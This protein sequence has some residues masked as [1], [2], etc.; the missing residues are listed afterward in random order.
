MDLARLV[1]LTLHTV[2]FVIA[3]GYYVILA[4]VILPGLVATLDGP[5]VGRTLLMVERR[6][7]PLLVVAIILF[8]T[9]G[10]YL[11]LTD[12]SYH[13]LGAIRDPW[14]SMMLLKH[15]V[16]VA[17]VGVG[18][19][20]DWL[21]RLVDEAEDEPTRAVALRRVR[22]TTDAAVVLGAVIVLLTA[23]AQLS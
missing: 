8:A 3:C 11:M 5:A 9:T 18:A 21:I 10:T 15:L 2:G 19:A 20:V 4:R 1:A 16:V 17:F 23:A 14:S 7:L 6:A 12:P 13:G 22:R